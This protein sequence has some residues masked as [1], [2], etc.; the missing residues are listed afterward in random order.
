MADDDSM[1]DDEQ[2]DVRYDLVILFWIL[3]SNDWIDS[4]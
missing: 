3:Y 2:L 1:S 4:G